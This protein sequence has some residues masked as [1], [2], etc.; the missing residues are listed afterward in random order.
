MVLKHLRLY[1]QRDEMQSQDPLALL[2]EESRVKEHFLAVV[3]L[4]VSCTVEGT[5][6]STTACKLIFS[7]EQVVQVLKASELGLSTKRVFARL[8][9]WLYIHEVKY[10]DL[11]TVINLLIKRLETGISSLSMM[12]IY[13]C[14]VLQ[15]GMKK[16]FSQ[17][18]YCH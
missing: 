13:M 14:F 6:F 9:N 16:V 2:L 3:D 12:A 4:L 11:T 17:R 1:M 7:V 18:P 15:M 10:S 8:L 5:E